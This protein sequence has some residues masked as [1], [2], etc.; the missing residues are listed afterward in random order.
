[1]AEVDRLERLAQP[2]VF[3]R[4]SAKEWSALVERRCCQIVHE[5]AYY[6]AEQG[7]LG[8]EH[9]AFY[10]TVRSESLRILRGYVKKGGD[11]S[12]ITAMLASDG[13]PAGGKCSPV[14]FR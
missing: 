8:P 11:I 12:D 14:P 9:E 2:E 5:E 6:R 4:M 3:A 13:V 10:E 1:M 7:A